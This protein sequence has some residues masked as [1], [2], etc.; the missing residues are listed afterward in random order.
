MGQLW[1]LLCFRFFKL[2]NGVYGQPCRYIFSYWWLNTG[3]KILHLPYFTD[4]IMYRDSQRLWLTPA[5]K[6][7]CCYMLRMISYTGLYSFVW[8]ISSIISNTLLF[9]LNTICISPQILNGLLRER[10]SC[11]TECILQLVWNNHRQFNRCRIKILAHFV[12]NIIYIYILHV[13]IINR[14]RKY[15]SDIQ[16]RFLT[17]YVIVIRWCVSLFSMYCGRIPHV[18][19]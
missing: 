7:K 1:H 5:S 10:E 18:S 17:D 4:H 3:C 12:C 2:Q 16:R 8:T 11:T 14:L 15:D 13:M 6:Q 19:K 9:I